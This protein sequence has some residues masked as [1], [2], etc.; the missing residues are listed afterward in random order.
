MYPKTLSFIPFI[1]KFLRSVPYGKSQ[2]KN[3][4]PYYSTTCSIK[5]SPVS[6][7]ESIS[8]TTN[9]HQVRINHLL[10]LRILNGNNYLWTFGSKNYENACTN[11]SPLQIS[12][13]PGIICH[14]II[15]TSYSK[16]SPTQNSVLNNYSSSKYIDSRTNTS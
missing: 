10:Y 3:I 2:A 4:G 15:Q 9:L 7:S 6:S 14:N 8:H 16:I 13:M 1:I 11:N 5:I 12:L